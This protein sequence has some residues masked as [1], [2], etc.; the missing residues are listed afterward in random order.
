MKAIIEKIKSNERMPVVLKALADATSEEIKNAHQ[1]VDDTEITQAGTWISS[2]LAVG[3]VE[4]TLVMGGL[5]HFYLHATDCDDRRG[6]FNSLLE[7]LSVS[8]S[9]AYR[10]IPVWEVFGRLLID[11]PKLAKFFVV[12]ALKLLAAPEVPPMAR[13]AAITM[14]RGQQRVR[15][16]QAK[17]LIA[18]FTPTPDQENDPEQPSVSA[19]S[20]KSRRVE[21]PATKPAAQAQDSVSL[22]EYAGKVIRFVLRPAKPKTPINHEAIIRDLEAALASYRKKYAQTKPQASSR[23]PQPE[24]A[25]VEVSHV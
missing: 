12:E 1:T 4:S 5:L 15:I 20:L 19:S 9:Q 16:E 22:W 18:K 6:L 25:K 11:E 14:A 7:D 24:A 13:Q 3:G 17:Q 8:K 2:K 10:C 23:Q 21:E